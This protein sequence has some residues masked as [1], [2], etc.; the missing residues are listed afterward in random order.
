LSRL[1]STKRI[2]QTAIKP[3]SPISPNGVTAN[4]KSL[5]TYARSYS[6]VLSVF[7]LFSLII[8]DA[9]EFYS[10]N[11]GAVTI[12]VTSR[13]TGEAQLRAQRE[14]EGRTGETDSEADDGDDDA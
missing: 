8:Q 2:T 9:N 4:P 1:N 12:E 6:I 14:L 7:V 11:A 10:R 13:V 3:T 5:I